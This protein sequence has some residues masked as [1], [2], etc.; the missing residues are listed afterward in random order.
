MLPYDVF[1]KSAKEVHKRTPEDRKNWPTTSLI[2]RSGTEAAVTNAYVL[3]IADV[4][5]EA[6]GLFGHNGEQVHEDTS[7]WGIS[8]YQFDWVRQEFM[9][10]DYAVLYVH[11]EPTIKV[12]KFM[13]EVSKRKP[14]DPRERCRSPQAHVEL[15]VT[16]AG[17]RRFANCAYLDHYARV[18]MKPECMQ[19]DAPV[20]SI[21]RYVD[22]KYLQMALQVIRDKE[23]DKGFGVP[24]YLHG[25]K[26]NEPLCVYRPY[27]RGYIMPVA[28]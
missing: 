16:G 22:A 14:G 4:G 24:I 5:F 18:E 6:E 21:Q 1:L 27:F 10:D 20:A 12:L 26:T 13:Q 7:D 15:T 19:A 28:Y 17:E 11:P 9:P 25:G 23:G 3:W 8:P 2:W